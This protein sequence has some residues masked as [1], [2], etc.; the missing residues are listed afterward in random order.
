MPGRGES[1]ASFGM[2]AG[3][4]GGG[5]MIMEM[6]ATGLQPDAVFSLWFFFDE[7]YSDDFMKRLTA[8]TAGMITAEQ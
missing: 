3:M 4:D 6:G 2:K 8:T 7:F 1:F 5:P